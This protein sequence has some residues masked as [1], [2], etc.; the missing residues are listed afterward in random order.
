MYRFVCVCI[1]LCIGL[2][3]VFCVC[4][5]VCV[6][7]LCVYIGLCVYRFV[8]VCVCMCV[9]VFACVCV[10]VVACVFVCMCLCKHVCACVC[11][12][13]YSSLKCI[14]FIHTALSYTLL[15]VLSAHIEIVDFSHHKHFCLSVLSLLPVLTNVSSFVQLLSIVALVLQKMVCHGEHTYLYSQLLMHSLA[16]ETKG[17][18][19]MRR[20]C[21]E[22]HKSARSKYVLINGRCDT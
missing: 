13:T 16:V 15:M 19:N 4:V 17:G 12:L 20:L 22:V 6:C 21:Q 8:C 3:I 7:V 10:C 5:Y 14:H 1:G 9:C 11:V 2:Y 18:S